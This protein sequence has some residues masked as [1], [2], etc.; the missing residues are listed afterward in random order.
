MDELALPTGCTFEV[1]PYDD[2]VF[3]GLVQVG[4]SAVPA[5]A[6]LAPGRRQPGGPGVD[7][8]RPGAGGDGRRRR[9]RRHRPAIVQRHVGRVG[10][11]GARRRRSSAVPTTVAAAVVPGVSVPAGLGPVEVATLFLDS[12]AAGDGATACALLAAEEMT[13]NFVEEA[14]TCAIELTL[15]VLGQGEFWSS[16]RHQRRRDHVVAGAVR[17]RGPR[18]RLRLARARGPERRR[19]PV[20]RHRE[21][22]V[23]HRG[24][25]QLDLE[26][27]QLTPPHP[28]PPT[29][30]RPIRTECVRRRKPQHHTLC[31]NSRRR[32]TW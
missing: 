8:S 15:Q 28:H 27:S 30:R 10:V 11:R 6:L 9:G 24:P 7:R 14:E 31:A 3:V 16:V 26:P 29:P 12:L 20:D 19:L 23:A 22:R 4:S 32:R 17:R 25:L 13:T 1:Q 18:R 2:G 5:E 21:R